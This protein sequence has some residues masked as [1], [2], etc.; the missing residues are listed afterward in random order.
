MSQRK[1][2]KVRKEDNWKNSKNRKGN[3][4]ENTE[5]ESRWVVHLA[6]ARVTHTESFFN[7]VSCLTLAAVA[8]IDTDAIMSLF[9][10]NL[11]C[12][13]SSKALHKYLYITLNTNLNPIHYIFQK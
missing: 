9:H 13:A 7:T 5:V 12:E 8:Y 1:N 3:T 4:G 10:C 6:V 11:S 2:W